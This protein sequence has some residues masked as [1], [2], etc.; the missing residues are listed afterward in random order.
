MA[1]T[2]DNPA[3]RTLHSRLTTPTNLLRTHNR[4]RPT[5]DNPILDSPF[6]IIDYLIT[7][8]QELTELFQDAL[9]CLWNWTLMYLMFVVAR[10]FWSYD[11][12]DWLKLAYAVRKIAGVLVGCQYNA[13]R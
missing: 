4:N 7:L 6:A 1:I 8:T 11:Q 12:S 9:P 2:K 13:R 5:Y 10:M 3:P